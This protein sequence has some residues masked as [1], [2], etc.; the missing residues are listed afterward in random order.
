MITKKTRFE[1]SHFEFLRLLDF[2]T[3]LGLLTLI[4]LFANSVIDLATSWNIEIFS[5]KIAD[6]NFPFKV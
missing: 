2:L 1:K 5:D 4:V 3:L 6:L